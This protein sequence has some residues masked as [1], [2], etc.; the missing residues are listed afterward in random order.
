MAAKPGLWST[1]T[2]VAQGEKQPAQGTHLRLPKLSL[3]P[4]CLAGNTELVRVPRASPHSQH[5]GV[6]TPS[7][8]RHPL[9]CPHTPLPR[10]LDSLLGPQLP[11]TLE[12]FPENLPVLRT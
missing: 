8:R 1:C 2:Y 7:A 3:P 5:R 11:G 9:S 4:T 6:R 10:F 12:R